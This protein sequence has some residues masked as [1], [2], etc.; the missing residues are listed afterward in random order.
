MNNSVYWSVVQDYLSTASPN[1]MAAPLRVTIEHD[2]PV[3]LGR[4]G[5]RSSATCIPAGST[6]RFGED[7]SRSHCYNAHIRWWATRSKA[8]ASLFAL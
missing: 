6:D 1:S 2:L 8:V 7:L 5:W 4:S 3:A